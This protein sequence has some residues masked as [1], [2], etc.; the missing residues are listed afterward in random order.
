MFRAT[1]DYSEDL[2]EEPRGDGGNGSFFLCIVYD[3]YEWFRVSRYP[4]DGPEIAL[5]VVD[6]A[7]SG[8]RWH[9]SFAVAVEAIWT[10]QFPTHIASIAWAII[11]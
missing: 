9:L 2:G 7:M 11:V 10:G 5:G 3:V 1:G 6:E 8:H 4:V